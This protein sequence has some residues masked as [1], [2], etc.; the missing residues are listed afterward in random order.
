MSRI[1]IVPGL[2]VRTYALPAARAAARAGHRVSLTAAPAWRGTP[3]RLD[4]FGELLARRIESRGETIDLLVGLSVGTQAA[5]VAASR[6]RRIRAL[7]LV[8]PTVDPAVRTRIRLLRHWLGGEE[9]DDAPG[10]RRSLPDW[11]R[12]GVLRIAVGFDSAVR[13]ALEEVMPGVEASTVVVHAEHDTLGSSEWARR[14]ARIAGGRFIERSGAPH[15]W[16]VDDAK[17]FVQLAGEILER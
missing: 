14:I 6:S 2:A 1:V 15:S 11:A 7:L 9:G 16:P 10:W 5:A 12:A 3:A 4:R 17:G 13:V 8:S